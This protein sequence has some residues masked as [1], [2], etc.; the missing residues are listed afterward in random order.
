MYKDIEYHPYVID[1]VKT[2]LYKTSQ[3]HYTQ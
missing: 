3:G 1:S 2:E